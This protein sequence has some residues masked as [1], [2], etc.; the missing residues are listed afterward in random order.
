MFIV[1]F[2]A[3]SRPNRDCPVVSSRGKDLGTP[4]PNPNFLSLAKD[5]KYAWVTHS[6]QL[7]AKP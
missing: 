5:S 6:E 4:P 3:I 1:I 2:A 7:L